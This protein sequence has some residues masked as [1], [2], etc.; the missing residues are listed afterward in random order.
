MLFYFYIHQ[1]SVIFT[2]NFKTN[3]MDNL[4]GKRIKC[5]EM[6]DDPNPV[7]A[8]EMGTVLYS[9]SML[10]H[11]QWDNG[12]NLGLVPEIDKWEVIND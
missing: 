9:N 8:G 6:V 11:V 4:K 2:Y 12:R 1:K 10:I 7:E 5:I 3:I